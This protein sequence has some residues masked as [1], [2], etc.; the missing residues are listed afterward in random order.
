M[1]IL[2]GFERRCAVFSTIL[3]LLV[4]LFSFWIATRQRVPGRNPPGDPVSVTITRMI[5]LSIACDQ[6]AHKVGRLP[7]DTV[8]L[9]NVVRPWSTNML[10]DGWGRLILLLPVTNSPGAMMLVSYGADGLPGGTG[11]NADISHVLK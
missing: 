6:Y 1:P 8:A 10:I 2:F 5:G 4:C 7:P 9:T 3:C 11:S